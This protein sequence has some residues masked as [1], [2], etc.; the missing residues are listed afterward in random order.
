MPG[1]HAGGYGTYVETLARQLNERLASLRS[2]LTQAASASEA[3]EIEA[4][5]RREHES[6]K[7]KLAE[8]QRACF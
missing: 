7:Q 4:E 1:F 5:I 8:A 3:N 6:C 2:R